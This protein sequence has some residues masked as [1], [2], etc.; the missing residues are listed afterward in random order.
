M[1]EAEDHRLLFDL[2]QKM[3]AYDPNERISMVEALR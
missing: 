1:A 3:L 2:I